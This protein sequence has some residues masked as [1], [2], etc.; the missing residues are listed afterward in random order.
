[1]QSLEP[2]DRSLEAYFTDIRD[3]PMFSAEE[4]RQLFRTYRVCAKC[5]TE[6][7][8]KL[9]TIFCPNE[10]CKA[11]RNLRSRDRLI[12]G[13]VRFVVR[14]AKIQAKK[15]KGA[16]YSS[17]LLKTLISAGNEGLMIAVDEFD[18][19]KNVRFLT[20]AAWWIKER[21][22]SEL[23]RTGLV[24][25][26]AYKQKNLRAQRKTSGTTLEVS[27]VKITGLADAEN[28]QTGDELEK[29]VVNKCGTDV[30]YKAMGSL[31]FRGRDK[32]IVLAYYGVRDEP[33]NLRQISAF[34]GLSSE[35]VRQLKEE[36]FRRLKN[37]LGLRQVNETNDALT[38]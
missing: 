3:A 27:H 33:K 14:M 16:S 17:E 29:E 1:M 13:A 36:S 20:Y 35:R 9:V 38:V 6:C 2:T 18:T 4:E 32:Y 28:C 22:L 26:P 7:P 31:E 24:H 11:K 37:Y 30:L 8:P 25:V 23:D 21:Q 15:A 5:G 19:T 10:V 12:E 34:L